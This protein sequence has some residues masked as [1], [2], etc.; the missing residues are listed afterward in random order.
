MFKF[1]VGVGENDA[2]EG[3]SSGRAAEAVAAKRGVEVEMYL[4]EIGTHGRIRGRRAE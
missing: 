3:I 4:E 2:S 1:D